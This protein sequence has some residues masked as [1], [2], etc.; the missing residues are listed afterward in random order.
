MKR[1][2]V[3]A[4]IL[5]ASGVVAAE[6]KN[7]WFGGLE[8]GSTKHEYSASAFGTNV[9]EKDSAGTQTIKVGK[10]FGDM[11]RLAVSYSRYNTEANVDTSSYGL[12]YDYM[13]YNNSDFTP[14]VGINIG[15]VNYEATGL[16]ASLVG[17]SVT[18]SSDT[19]DVSGAYY[20]ANI[21][22]LYEVHGNFDLEL[23]LR[24]IKT[25]GDDSVILTSGA[26][27]VPVGFETDN[28]T[29]WYIGVNYNF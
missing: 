6:V 20:G 5:L 12:G 26:A 19:I 18:A 24:F 10:Y 14:F 2:V 27:S 15:K 21:G 8:I 7:N 29:Q 17:T 4:S 13:F 11:G 28:A 9:S 16:Q 1:N 22:T 3:I 25:T 23:G